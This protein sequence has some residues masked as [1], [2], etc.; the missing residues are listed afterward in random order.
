MSWLIAPSDTSCTCLLIN[1]TRHCTGKT[2]LLVL[3]SGCICTASCRCCNACYQAN[4]TRHCI[5]RVSECQD[6]QPCTAAGTC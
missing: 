4:W 1:W 6:K 5:A 2:M 3:P